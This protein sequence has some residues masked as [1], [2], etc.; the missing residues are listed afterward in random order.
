MA[1]SSEDD[2]P[3]Q[4]ATLLGRD[5]VRIRKTDA[6]PP[7]VSVIDVIS[8]FTA[9]D[10]NQAAEQ[11]RRLIAQY[12]DVKANCTYVKVPDARGRKGQKETP[13]AGN[14]DLL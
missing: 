7:R 13:V 10:A 8:M 14:L 12:P 11:L 3:T 4:L 6:T 5:V 1:G 2:I 9:K